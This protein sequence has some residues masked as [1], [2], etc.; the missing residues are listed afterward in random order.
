MKKS[1]DWYIYKQRDQYEN[2]VD[3]EKCCYQVHNDY[4]VGFHQC[5]R[6]KKQYIQGFG[7]CIQHYKITM[8]YLND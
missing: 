1:I 6:K 5:T 2:K 4:G 3:L 8:E 7:F